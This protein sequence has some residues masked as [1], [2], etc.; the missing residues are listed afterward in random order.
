MPARPG[1]GRILQVVLGRGR[2]PRFPNAPDVTA[3]ARRTTLTAR[4]HPCSG[5]DRSGCC[6]SVGDPPCSK[7]RGDRATA[8]TSTRPR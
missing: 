5:R 2:R 7:V 6:P 1:G 8:A 3:A 4:L